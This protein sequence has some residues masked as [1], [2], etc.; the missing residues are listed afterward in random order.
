MRSLFCCSV[1]LLDLDIGQ[2]ECNPPG[3]VSLHILRYVSVPS[4]TV[5]LITD[6]R[7]SKRIAEMILLPK[8]VSLLVA[9]LLCDELPADEK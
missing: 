1:A 6:L 2:P 5:M 8:S 3:S 7:I 9:P 4:G